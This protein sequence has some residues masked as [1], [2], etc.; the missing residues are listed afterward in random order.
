MGISAILLMVETFQYGGSYGCP[1]FV[2]DGVIGMGNCEQQSTWG[3]TAQCCCTV[4][5]GREVMWDGVM[6]KEMG[7]YDKGWESSNR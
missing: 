3:G 2:V 6:G 7:G 4:I 5:R 1:T